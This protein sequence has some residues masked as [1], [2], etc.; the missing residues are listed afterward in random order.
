MLENGPV[1]PPVILGIGGAWESTVH[2]RDWNAETFPLGSRACTWNVCCPCVRPVYVLGDVQ[3][4]SAP[5]SSWH[6]KEATES[7]EENEN[8]ADVELTVP[9]GPDDASTIGGGVV[10]EK[11]AVMM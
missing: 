5:V 9:A 1:G 11:F 6:L 7:V 3:D 2:V 8:V 4:P 10:S